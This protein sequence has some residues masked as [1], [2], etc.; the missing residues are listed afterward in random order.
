MSPSRW[1][2]NPLI[3]ERQAILNAVSIFGRTLPGFI[4]DRLGRFNTMIFFS[5]LS[6]ILVLALWL[7][8]RGNVPCGQLK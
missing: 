6:T 5:F 7:P 8:A 3:V 4:A 1:K 2:N